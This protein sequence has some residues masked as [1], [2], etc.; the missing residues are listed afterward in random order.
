MIKS[1]ILTLCVILITFCFSWFIFA[2]KPLENLDKNNI[3]AEILWKI[4]N[5]EDNYR[6]YSFWPDHKGMQPGRAPHGP[7]HK[8]YINDII[9]NVIPISNKTIPEGG[10]IVKESFDIDKEF[11]SISVMAK[12]KDCNPSNND[13]FWAQY[14]TDGKAQTS[15][16]IMNCI[17][18]HKAFKKNDFVMFHRLDK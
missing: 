5:T 2:V 7:Y 1:I 12:V 8:I 11:V 14:S 9:R 10:I 4:I 6:K 18:C 16:K 3:N 13:W 15:G 17:N